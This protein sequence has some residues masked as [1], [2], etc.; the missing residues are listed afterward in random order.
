MVRV[1]LLDKATFEHR[2]EG[3]KNI[4]VEGMD[5]QMPQSTSAWCIQGTVKRLV[6]LEQNLCAHVYFCWLNLQQNCWAKG[7]VWIPFEIP[8]L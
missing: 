6:C 8:S 1:N 4:R 5:R 3:E 2:L 7:I